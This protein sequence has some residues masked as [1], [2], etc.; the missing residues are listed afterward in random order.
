MSS[1]P[2]FSA[3]RDVHSKVALDIIIHITQQ[4]YPIILLQMT[5]MLYVIKKENDIRKIHITA[6]PRDN[7]FVIKV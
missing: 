4:Y 3:V 1:P 2:V 7:S 6:M 5:H